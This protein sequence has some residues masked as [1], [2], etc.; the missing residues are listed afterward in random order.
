MY[1]FLKILELSN[2]NFFLFLKCIFSAII[3][4]SFYCY[5]Y[6]IL[7]K[8]LEYINIYFI[9]DPNSVNGIKC[10]LLTYQR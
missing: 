5:Y 8:N 7:F 2:L 10:P 3:S 1:I 4:L 6:V 9:I